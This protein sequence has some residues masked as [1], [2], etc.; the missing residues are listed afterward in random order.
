MTREQRFG[1]AALAALVIITVGWWALALWPAGGDAEW[2]A[3]TRAVC[4]GSVA[5]G[6]PDARGWALLIGQPLGMGA[7]LLI[8]WGDPTLQAL[9][10]VARFT[11]GRAVLAGGALFLLAAIVTASVRIAAA[12]PG[13]VDDAAG[14]DLAPASYPRLDRPAPTP[15][16]LVDQRGERLDLARFRDRPVLVTFAFA[17]CA[18]VCPVLV[19]DVLDAQARSGERPG[20]SRPAVVVLTV[21]PWRDTPARL[22]S[23]A[24][25]WDLPEDAFVLSGPAED[26]TRELAA[27][28]VSIRRDSLT[29]DVTHPAL[30]Y[31]LDGRGRIAYAAT[32]GAAYLADLVD[33]L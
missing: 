6:L 7:L 28:D 5:N 29:G 27:W 24:R 2:L 3:R 19:R 4:F 21:D 11:A 25:Q 32:G 31:V 16:A 18:T 30:V 13:S 12:S 15:L 17:H 10:R 20:A 1:L 9:R 26:V 14:P 22:P 23:L 33:R 8:G